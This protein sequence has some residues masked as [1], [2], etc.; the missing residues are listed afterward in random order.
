MSTELV[1]SNA[2]AYRASTDAAGL[3]REIVLKTAT[4]IQ[5]RRHVNVEGWQAIAIAHGCTASADHVERVTDEGMSGFKATG[6]IRRM[7]DGQ[8]IARGEGFLGDDEAMWAKRPV[9]ARRAMAQTRAISRACRSAFA[10]VVVMIDAGLSTTPAEEMAGDI[11]D[12]EFTPADPVAGETRTTGP[13]WPEGPYPNKTQAM[14]AFRAVKRDGESAATLAEFEAVIDDA[15]PLIA[16]FRLADHP[17]WYGGNGED[18]YESIPAWIERRRGELAQLEQVKEQLGD[19][20]KDPLLDE[21]PGSTESF[22]MMI[23]QMRE[24]GAPI[25]LNKWKDNNRDLVN[26]LDKGEVKAFRK[27]FEDHME[28]LQRAQKVAA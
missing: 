18:K 1:K 27:A 21:F 5:G 13:S 12:A 9:Y 2:E 23:E 16:Q 15:Q 11:V 28:T 3:C 20:P 19:E 24:N 6:I 7:S 17:W 22:R 26:S 4:K 10:H 8:E 25:D 14:T